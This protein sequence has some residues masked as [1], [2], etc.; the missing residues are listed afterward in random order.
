MADWLAGWL[1]G[2]L[3]FFSL[4]LRNF[5]LFRKLNP[6]PKRKKVLIISTFSKNVGA[7]SYL[8]GE[9]SCCPRQ[10]GK[11]YLSKDTRKKG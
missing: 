4:S 10:G 2:W 5:L 1:A 6:P 3:A 11:I 7:L 8:L 9:G